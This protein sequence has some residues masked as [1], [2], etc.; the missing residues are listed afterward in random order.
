MGWAGR[1]ARLA[2]VLRT[3]ITE[4]KGHAEPLPSLSQAAGKLE[5]PMRPHEV[6]VSACHGYRQKWATPPGDDQHSRVNA[7]D[8]PELCG[9]DPGAETELPPRSPRG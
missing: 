6:G 7:R 5:R 4:C 9:R 3:A 1:E 8:A 2:V